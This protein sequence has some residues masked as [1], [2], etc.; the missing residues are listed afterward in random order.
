MNGLRGTAALLT[1]LV[2]AACGS[3]QATSEDHPSQ[4]S[5]TDAL[6][7][8]TPRVEVTYDDREHTSDGPYRAHAVLL[9]AGPHHIRYE[10]TSTGYAPMLFIYDGQRLLVHDAESSQPWSLFEAPEQHPEEFAAV[11][12]T[13]TPPDSAEFE[14]G[15]PSA[16]IIGHRRI[17]GRTAVGYHCAAQFLADGSGFS[18]RVDWLDQKTSILLQS[19]HFHATAFDEHPRLDASSFSTEP[20]AGARVARYAEQMRPGD[21]PRKAPGF[22]LER[23]PKPADDA[24]GG[25]GTV[26]LS[27]YVHQPLVIEFF[28]SDLGFDPEGETCHGC[29]ASM[30]TL[31]RLTEGGTS[32]RVLAVQGGEAGKPGFPLIPQGLRVDVVNDPDS[33]VQHSYGL[34]DLVGFAFIGSD[35]LIHQVFD[36]AATDQQLK[37]ALHALQ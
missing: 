16:T 22:E 10:F 12:G 36:K 24:A 34:S 2:A 21:P 33:D 32:P 15:C 20:P 30:L 35:G 29:V 5:T 37:D 19:G 1:L 3:N 13:F 7:G 31:Q 27:D 26:S 11:S 8:A 23:V 28:S 14:K 9:A 6:R 17:L 18:A 4:H 25:D